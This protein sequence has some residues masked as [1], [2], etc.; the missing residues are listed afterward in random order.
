MNQAEAA[1]ITMSLSREAMHT[2]KPPASFSCGGPFHVWKI[3]SDDNAEWNR[4]LRR[5][6]GSWW[7]CTV[8]GFATQD[9][10]GLGVR[11]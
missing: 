7:R 6:E 8:C 5:V 3:M 10:R 9:P 1:H 2:C 11:G 4:W